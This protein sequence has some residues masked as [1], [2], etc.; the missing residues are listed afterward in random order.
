VFAHLGVFA[1]G[2]TAEAAQAVLGVS[3]PA[4]PSLEALIEASLVQAQVVAGETRFTLLETIR[5]YALERLALW[6]ELDA[7]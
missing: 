2:S 7:A 1:G 4:L 6:G 3:P 5:E